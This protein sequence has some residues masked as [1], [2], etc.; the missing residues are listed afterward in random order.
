MNSLRIYPSSRVQYRS[1]AAFTLVEMLVVIGIITLILSIALP[2]TFTARR[3][4]SRARAARD[5]MAL[6]SG[7]DEYKNQFGAYPLTNG[8]DGATVLAEALTGL[9]WDVPTASLKPIRDPKSN[10]PRSALINTDQFNVH[11]D[12]PTVGGTTPVAPAQRQ[13]WLRDKAGW[14]ICYFPAYIPSPD[15]RV[16]ANGGFVRDN[17]APASLYNHKDASI[18]HVNHDINQA[19]V[20]LS[21]NHMQRLLGD[22]NVNGII[23]GSET[24]Q[25][26]SAFILWAPGPDGAYGLDTQPKP[27]SDDVTNFDLPVQY[28]R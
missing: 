13:V 11:T 9:Y 17:S 12:L 26:T 24:P 7:L 6:S 8:R 1:N 25:T 28:V 19:Q 16:A 4:A 15:I 2:V 27:K 5:L 22:A 18:D 23:D 10:R 21:L 3:K 14:P 20:T